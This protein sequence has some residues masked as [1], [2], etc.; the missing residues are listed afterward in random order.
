L[1]RNDA[2]GRLKRCR[3]RHPS[4]NLRHPSESS[5]CPE[6][7]EEEMR[8]NGSPPADPESSCGSSV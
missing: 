1:P 8:S 4:C 5:I 7:Q 2:V 6:Y 3:L